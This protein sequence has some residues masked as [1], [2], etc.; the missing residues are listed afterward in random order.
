MAS[1][2]A[3]SEATLGAVLAARGPAFL[4]GQRWFAGKGRRLAAVRLR[5][6]GRLPAAPPG[7][8]LALLEVAFADGEVDLYAVPVVLDEAD[9]DVRDALDDPAFGRALL[10]AVAAE[11]DVPLRAGRVRCLRT[12]AWPAW[13][14][15][16]APRRLAGEQSHTSLRYGDLLVLKAFRHLH[17]GPSP[18]RELGEFLTTRAAFPHAPALAGAIEY[19]GSDDVVTTLGVVQRFVPN[20]GDGWQWLLA[21]LARLREAF[22]AEAAPG[23]AVRAAAADDLDVLGALGRVTAALHVALAGGTGPDLAA[24]PLTA[25]DVERW[26]ARLAEG[27]AATTRAVRGVIRGL[28]GAARAE[29][30]HFLDGARAS[31]AGAGGLFA[32]VRRGCLKIRVHGD[33]HLGQTLRTAT[34]FVILDFEGEPG[35]TLAERRAR[36]CA[37]VDV[38]GMLRS[39][40]YAAAMVRRESPAPWV[41]DWRRLG[42]RTFLDGYLDE[43]AGAPAPLVPAARAEVEAALAV[44]ELDK[45]LYEVRYEVGHR[46]AWADVP[47]RD[48][49]RLL[50]GAEPP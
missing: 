39:L 18:E 15:P 3:P 41:E 25:A 23:A 33:L 22:G 29:A 30:E 17:P 10:A 42:R 26:G 4:A 48:A 1:S 45:A 46:P 50:A 34:G 14:T 12:A 21:R 36:Q 6:A 5:D 8:W 32:L 7:A 11:A 38:A 28:T 43:L 13:E 31:R 49:V 35:R 2:R 27:L 47:L 19:R 44:L 24:E 16:P 37:L 20:A 9:G 40:D